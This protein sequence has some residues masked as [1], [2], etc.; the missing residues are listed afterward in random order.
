MVSKAL[1]KCP[2]LPLHIPGLLQEAFPSS[3]TLVQKLHPYAPSILFIMPK[4]PLLIRPLWAWGKE[5]VHFEIF[6]SSVA[7][8]VTGIR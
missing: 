4:F 6:A 5:M 8:R 1:H 2:L 7:N 3:T